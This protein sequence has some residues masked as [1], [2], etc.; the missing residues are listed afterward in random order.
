[1]VRKVVEISLDGGTW[2]SV[3]VPDN[4][5]RE[6]EFEILAYHVKDFKTRAEIIRAALEEFEELAEDDE[7]VKH[8]LYKEGFKALLESRA[9]TYEALAVK[10]VEYIMREATADELLKII[11]PNFFAAGMIKVSM[12][13][14]DKIR[15]RLEE[16]DEAVRGGVDGV[17][18]G[19]ADGR[20]DAREV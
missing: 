17:E 9:A 2:A 5:T 16:Y 8:T 19:G 6:D 20:N 10:I 18:E 13:V 3:V 4:A 1:M 15:K 12:E 11:G 7:N 14:L